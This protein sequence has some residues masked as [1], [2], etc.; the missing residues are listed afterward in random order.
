MM[1]MKQNGKVITVVIS[2]LLFA[3]L[4]MLL[5]LVDVQAIGP[6]DTRIGLSSLNR[7]VFETL[8][9]HMLWYE[10]TDWLGIAAILTGLIFAVTGLIQ[11]IRRKSIWKVDREILALGVLYLIVIGIYVLFELVIVNYRPILMPGSTR[12]EASFPSSHTMLVCVIMGSAMQLLGNYVRQKKLYAVFRVLCAVIIGI[13]VFGRIL[14]GA[15]WF[16]D[17]LGGVLISVMLLNLYAVVLVEIKSDE[18]K[19]LYNP[20]GRA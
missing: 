19:R 16:T 2:G 3:G 12:P 6:E 14:S 7:F 13:T 5:C 9:V 20:F 10:I 1:P 4:I 11:W 8:G 18:W 15:H 17:I